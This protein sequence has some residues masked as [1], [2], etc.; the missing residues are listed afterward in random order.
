MDHADAAAKRLPQQFKTKP[1]IVALLRALVSPA[2]DLEAVFWDLIERSVDTANDATLDLIGRI[3]G[4]DRNGL[5]NDTF[6]R[7]IR[8]RIT[9]R[10]SNGLLETVIKVCRL[11]VNDPNLYVQTQITPIATL[12][13]RL[14][15]VAVDNAVAAVVIAFLLQTVSAGVR[16]TV[17]WSESIPGNTFT[18]DIVPGLDVGHLA[19]DSNT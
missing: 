2:Q 19:G 12:I 11:I 17:E 13:V 10:R 1:R 5:D 9:T 4:Q 3:V 14:R 6:R 16:V 15:T 8:A 7:Y 18:L